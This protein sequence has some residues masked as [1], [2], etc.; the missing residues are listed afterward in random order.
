MVLHLA[1]DFKRLQ[2]QGKEYRWPRPERC[3]ECGRRRPWG[4]GYVGRC[5]DGCGEPLW[6]K[7][8]RCPDCGTVYTLRPDSHYRGF[9]AP[10]RVILVALLGKLKGGRWIARVSRQRQQYWR[11]GLRR[12][13]LLEGVTAVSR[14]GQ[15]AASALKALVVR[16]I[17]VSTH[18]VSYRQIRRVDAAPELVLAVP[19]VGFAGH[20]DG[21]GS[22]A[23]SA[24]KEPGNE[25]TP[26]HGAR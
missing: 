20:L 15:V 4:H 21:V 11:Q 2:E 1:V 10:W 13:L 23:D 17:I 12:Q 18:S 22:T 19:V 6:M 25:P 24:L 9:W 5:F 8:Y 16:L 26:S 3:L 7:R 14:P